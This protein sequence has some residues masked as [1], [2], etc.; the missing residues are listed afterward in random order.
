MPK[1]NLYRSRNIRMIA[2]VAGGLAEYFE[3]R[4]CSGPLIMDPGLLFWRHRVI[5]LYYCLDHHP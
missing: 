1:S 3:C 5:S 4:C 2:G